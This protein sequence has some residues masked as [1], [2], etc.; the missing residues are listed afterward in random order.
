MPLKIING[1]KTFDVERKDKINE[2]FA[3]LETD[4]IKFI[5]K[6]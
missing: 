4:R 2:Y 3:L 5:A 6:V 1:C